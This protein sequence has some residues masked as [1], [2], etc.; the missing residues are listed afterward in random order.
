MVWLVQ[1]IPA[2]PTGFGAKFLDSVYDPVGN[3]QLFGHVWH[4]TSHF[5]GFLQFLLGKWLPHLPFDLLI[6]PVFPP[7]WPIKT[8]GRL[9]CSCWDLRWRWGGRGHHWSWTRWNLDGIPPGRAAWEAATS[10]QLGIFM[11][12]IWMTWYD[13]L[14][15]AAVSCSKHELGH[16]RSAVWLMPGSFQQI[17]S[18]KMKMPIFDKKMV[19]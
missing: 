11:E 7:F 8:P 9:L 3:H 1:G 10:D 2:F 6:Y 13:Q 4:F 14:L 5:P 17:S 19:A 15:L 12:K 16:F 18:L